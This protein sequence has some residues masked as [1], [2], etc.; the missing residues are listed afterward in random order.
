MRLDRLTVKSQEAM[1]EAESGA[2]EGQPA[3]RCRTPAA[4]NSQ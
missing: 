3:V 4:S 2:E 1:Q